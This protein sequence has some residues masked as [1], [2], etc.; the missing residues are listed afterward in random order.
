MRHHLVLS[1]FYVCT[2]GGVLVRLPSRFDVLLRV[3]IDVHTLIPLRLRGERLDFRLQ[4]H[5]VLLDAGV[6][7]VAV[8]MAMVVAPV[9]MMMA[10]VMVMVVAPMVFAVAVAMAMSTAL[11]MEPLVLGGLTSLGRVL[12][13]L[14]WRPLSG[15]CLLLLLLL[16]SSTVR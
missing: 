14:L 12:L 10:V 11:G 4:P 3:H 2:N 6:P 13:V 8:V 1:T 16:L 7:V 9:F 15:V 5:V